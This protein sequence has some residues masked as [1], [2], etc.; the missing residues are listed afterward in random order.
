MIGNFGGD[1]GQV[2]QKIRFSNN[3]PSV[4]VQYQGLCKPIKVVE[5][6]KLASPSNPSFE[7]K[8]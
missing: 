4:K 6:K 3:V 5:L 2:R 7:T 8:G 1:E